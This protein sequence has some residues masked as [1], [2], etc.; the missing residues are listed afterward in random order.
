MKEQENA[1]IFFLRVFSLYNFFLFLQMAS[2]CNWFNW[3]NAHYL[4]PSD[5]PD[6]FSLPSPTPEW[7]QGICYSQI[8]MTVNYSILFIYVL[9]VSL[10][11]H[12][13]FEVILCLLLSLCLNVCD[14]C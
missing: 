12:I 6:H 9:F 1:R 7:P 5:E 10:L 4:L 3:S 11:L 8:K 13:E 14:F 2:G